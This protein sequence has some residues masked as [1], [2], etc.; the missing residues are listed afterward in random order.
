MEKKY[1]QIEEVA[2]KTDLTKR[3]IRYYEDIELIK[4]IRTEALY[5]LYTEEDIE[6]ISR[7]KSLKDKLGFSLNEVKDIFELEQNIKKIFALEDYDIQSIEYALKLIE[8]QIKLIDEKELV[9]HRVKSKFLEIFE[10]LVTKKH[11]S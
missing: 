4:P 6:K 8:Y 5:R 1:Y 7:I 3:A 11:K 9:L 2:N 10:E